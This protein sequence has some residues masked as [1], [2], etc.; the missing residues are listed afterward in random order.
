VALLGLPN[1]G[2]STLYNRLTGG[3]AQIANWPGLTV[4]LLRGTMPNDRPG[5]PTTLVDLPGIHDLSGSSE[6]EAIV[7]RFLRNTPPDLLLVVLNAS[8]V[9]GQLRLVLQLRQPG[10]PMVVALNMS[11]EARRL[12][13]AID[14]H[15]LAADLGVPVVAISARHNQ[16]IRDLIAAVQQG[17]QQP[18]PPIDQTLSTAEATLERLVA[19]SV[20]LPVRLLNRRTR[21]VD[22]LLLHPLV[23]LFCFWASSWRCFS[24]SMSWGHRCRTCWAASWLGFNPP[25]SNP[26]WLVSELRRSCV[27]F[28]WTGCGWV[29]PPWPPFC[30]SSFSSI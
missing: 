26:A 18:R 21:R 23:D 28:W 22:R 10:L 5:H 3:N 30:R 4:E 7:Q 17:G 20:R 16:G 1:T 12:G 2:K 6:D 14:H 29:W 11:D 24:C 15:R 25:C 8:Q 13:I 19:N 27:G 9:T